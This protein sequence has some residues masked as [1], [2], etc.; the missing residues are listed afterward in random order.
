MEWATSFKVTGVKASSGFLAQPERAS[1]ALRTRAVVFFIDIIERS[2]S[3][4][5]I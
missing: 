2:A 1:K 3:W 5:K 4:E